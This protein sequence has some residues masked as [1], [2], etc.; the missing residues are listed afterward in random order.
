LVNFRIISKIIGS[1]LFIEAFFMAWCVGIA[2][3]YEE[4]DTLAFLLSMLITFGSA[5][6]FLMIGRKSENTLNR[7]DAYVVVTAVWVIFSFFG[8]L[9]FLIHG[10]IPNVT[11]AF[12]ETISGFTTTGA[13]ILDDVEVLPHGIL[14]WRSLTQ[15]IGGLG[16]VFFTIAILPSLVGGSVKVFAAEATG[17]IKAKMHPRL[18]TTA[19]WIWSIYLLLTICCGLAFWA[20]GMEWFDALNYSMTTTATGGF[21]IHNDSL[22]F[23]QDAKVDY[24]AILFQFLS[25]INFTLLYMSIFKGRL[26]LLFKNSEFKLY[27]CLVAMATASITLILMSEVG[28]GLDHAFRSGLFQVVSFM[29]TTGI[30]ND[31]V[32]RWPHITWII[33]GSVMFIGACAG[34]TSGG[35]KCIRAV[36][37][38]KTLRNNFRQSLHPNAVLPVK[39]NGQSVPQ[40]RIVSLFAFFTLFM[41]MILVTA[42]IMIVS[43]IDTINSI[44]IALSCV[45]NIGP[46]LNNDIGA[47]I[48]WS[49]MPEYIKWTLSLLMLMGRLEILTVLVLFTR[50][51]WKEN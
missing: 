35:F 20:V 22:A 50:S 7:H 8:M 21:S 9:P 2:F 19:K 16:I 29:T 11:D 4:D 24:I 23:F 38:L 18:S 30:F 39:I 32:A 5:F 37:T 10:C 12:F 6:S 40:S 49:G 41:F 46:S 1:L 33:L 51:F 34:S 42:A 45:S 15:W 44:V 36:M 31:D 17:P 14:F 47:C 26:G 27:I 43:G 13:S 3:S 48:T 28:Y 25:G